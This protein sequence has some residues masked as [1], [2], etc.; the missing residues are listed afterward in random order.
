MKKDKKRFSFECVNKS[1]C[2]QI[3]GTIDKSQQFLKI[4]RCQKQHDCGGVQPSKED[5]GR[6]RNVF[7]KILE[8]IPKSIP[9]TYA[10]NLN[11]N[12][13]KSREGT[14]LVNTN[15]N[16]EL[17]PISNYQANTLVQKKK[18]DTFDD[19]IKGYTETVGLIIQLKHDD[20][21]GVY[22]FETQ[23]RIYTT[24]NDTIPSGEM[25]HRCFILPSSMIHFFNN[26]RKGGTSDG[27]HLTSRFGGTKL[28]FTIR[29]SNNQNITVCHAFCS[30]N[31]NKE[32][33]I[34][35]KLMVNQTKMK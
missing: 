14:S 19:H 5:G 2:F 7:T 32:N 31:E 33:W 4:N 28:S 29:D 13:Y 12:S 24:G 16:Q 9:Q 22:V 11:S 34:C 25:F 27:A 3:C 35:P 23:P 26:S 10:V 6:V 8:L 20:P 17:P 18:F 15:F 30:G 21:E 1:C